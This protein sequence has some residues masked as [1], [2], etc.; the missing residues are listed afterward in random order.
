MADDKWYSENF[1][2]LDSGGNP[3][4]KP[5]S[6]KA[7]PQKTAADAA[8]KKTVAAKGGIAPTPASIGKPSSYMVT[9]QSFSGCDM[10]ASFGLT[11]PNGVAVNS[12][13]GTLQTMTYSIF[14]DKTPVR[15]VGN[16]NAKDYVWGP[17]T[18][19]GSLMFAVLNKHW[20]Y[21]LLE[22]IK[23]KGSLG[24][25]HF[26]VDEL[27]PFDVTVSFKNEYG[28]AARLALYGVRIVSEAQT[29]SIND[30]FTENTYQFVATDIDY[31]AN[32]GG[33][34]SQKL[35]TAATTAAQGKSAGSAKTAGINTPKKA[36]SM[37]TTPAGPGS[38]LQAVYR[39]NNDAKGVKVKGVW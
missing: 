5:V 4:T 33:Y 13:I 38:S 7:I 12:V 6:N 3:I 18:I 32:V 22:E 39:L 29:M 8:V 2:E 24:S 15:A 11:L 26:L 25:A 35:P 19:A 20:A 28:V 31:L 14:M 21:N 37:G 16:I 23:Q 27:L 36:F 9:N 17:R 30:L 1:V 34:T 10:V